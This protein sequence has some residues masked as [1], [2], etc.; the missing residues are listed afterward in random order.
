MIPRR[1]GQV[2]PCSVPPPQPPTQPQHC[3]HPVSFRLEPTD[4]PAKPTTLL[5]CCAQLAEYKEQHDRIWPE[6]KS[7]LQSVGLINLS[8]W[9]WGSRLFYYGE[10][11]GKEP[12]QQ[13]GWAL[14]LCQASFTLR[15]PRA[16]PSALAQHGPSLVFDGWGPCLFCLLLT[17]AHAGHGSLLQNAPRAGVGGT[18]I[19]GRLH[20]RPQA[21]SCQH[22]RQA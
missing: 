1:R 18:S 2:L 7:A 12:F 9:A 8:I 13:V 3:P 10:Y 17:R 21:N 19:L 16:P 15:P 6:I 5:L 22:Y 20:R 11:A 4:T 14:L